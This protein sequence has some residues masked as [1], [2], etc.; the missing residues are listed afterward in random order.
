MKN[1]TVFENQTGFFACQNDPFLT[2]LP[3]ETDLYALTGYTLEDLMDT[4]HGH[5]L[6]LL[7]FSLQPAARQ[8]IHEQLAH[9]DTAE[10]EFQITKK[11]QERIHVLTKIRAQKEVDGSM[12]IYGLFLALSHPL[13]HVENTQRSLE[14][15]QIILEQTESIIFEWDFQTDT[16]AFSNTF[17]ELFGYQPVTEHFSDYLK[18]SVH[19]HPK[20]LPTFQEH[21]HTLEQGA[22][23]QTT[24]IRIQKADGSYL[25][26]QIRASAISDRE[27]R[28]LKIVGIILNIDEEKKAAAALKLRAERDIL[29]KLFNKDTGRRLTEQYLAETAENLCCVMLIIDMDNFKL[30]NDRFG[31]L[32]G[33]Q[34]LS[35]A[36]REIQ[37]LFR[38]Q[39]ILARVGGDEFLV[40]MKDV[41]DR[42]LVRNRCQQLIEAFSGLLSEKEFSIAL[43][44]S[45]GAA[46][47]PLHG[48]SYYQ[49]FLHADKA[50]YQ[51]KALGKACFSIYEESQ[52]GSKEQSNT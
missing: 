51:A 40:L 22:S 5:L 6:E 12:I 36:A 25:W 46:F 39:D 2:L 13:K 11:N 42:E 19:F 43:S 50:L 23:Y 38:S 41:S 4:F 44:C 29:T 52:E 3:D 27:G 20:D 28:L 16:I 24:Q 9:G 17:L 21:F 18:H 8:I 47:A 34:I 31:H 37:Q 35:Q 10:A 30:V 1:Q 48:A 7:P 14:Q 33:D 32:F 15:Y 49:L 45:I 26:C